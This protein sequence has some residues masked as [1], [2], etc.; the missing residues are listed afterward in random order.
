MSTV[1]VGV[2]ALQGGFH[3]HVQLTR[4]AAAWL[5]T[6][7]S[8]TTPSPNADIAAIEVRTDAELRRCDALIIPGG[9]ST[10]ISFVATQSGLMEPLREFVKVKRKPV[11]GTCAGAILLA[12][13]ANA[14][15][16][17]GQELIGG[18]GV[19]VHRNHFGRQ[20]ESFV[21]DLELP[22]LSQGDGGAATAPAP[23]PGVFIRAPIV[24]EILT[25]EAAAPSV[26]VLAVLPGRKTMAAEGVSQSKADDAVGD[27]VAVKQDNIFATSFH[28]ELTNDMR[29]HVWWLKQVLRS[30]ASTSTSSA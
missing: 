23:Y 25:T 16:K 4:K 11:W 21:A 3:E 22:F 15:K 10:T 18:L 13:E 24:E 14:T 8:P 5:A 19:R 17:G 1:T 27:I 6:A 9:E 26:Q 12:D 20:M 30:V 29:I 7:Q 28:P 2:L